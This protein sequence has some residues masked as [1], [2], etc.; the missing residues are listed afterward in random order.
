MGDAKRRKK[1]STIVLDGAQCCIY[2]GGSTIADTIDHVPPRVFFA[3]RH[4]PKGLEFPACKSCNGGSR[5]DELA[6]AM[7]CRMYPDSVSET[8]KGELVSLVRSVSNNCSGLL[9]ELQP[10][11]RQRKL[12]RRVREFPSDA[13]VLNCSGPILNQAIRRFGAKIGYA[14]HYQLY[15]THIP[16]KGGVGVWWFTNYQALTGDMPH[17]LIDMLGAP[18]TLVQGRWE[19][20]DQFRYASA[21]SKEGTISA[22]FATFRFSFAVCA[23]AATDI[24]MV[25]P[26][27]DVGHVEVFR[28]GWLRS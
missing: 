23:A 22:H 20:G 5:L 9:E 11:F 21:G 25:C 16:P 3:R 7:V 17:K 12:A 18:K 6:A 27:E 28:P 14:L 2:C 26:P 24:N 19:V 1:L 8:E 15:G 10:S 4:R 13:G